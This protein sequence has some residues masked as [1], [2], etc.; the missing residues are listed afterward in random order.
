MLASAVHV[1][2]VIE[3]LHKQCALQLSSALLR[4]IFFSLFLI[5]PVTLTI[6]TQVELRTLQAHCL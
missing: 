3:H 5:A 4:L 2:K 1:K 6:F